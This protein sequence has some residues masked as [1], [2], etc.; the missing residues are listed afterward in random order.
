M[1][2]VLYAVISILTLAS[3]A[4]TYS[5]SGSSNVSML[6]GQKLYLKVYKDTVLKNIDSCDVV[7]GHFQFQGSIDSVRIA[8]IFVDDNAGLPVVLESGEIFVKIDNTQ[9][10]VTGTPLNDK[11]S[12]FREKFTQLMNQSMDLVHR[13]DQAIMN[14]KDMTVVN[15]QLA[16]E[17]ANINKKMDDLVTTFVTDNF[18]N[19]LGPYVFINTCLSRYEVP[20]LD[21][22]IEDIMSKA[23]D[24]FKNNIHVKEYYEAAQQNQ[25]IMNGMQDMPQQTPA[26]SV[27]PPMDGPTPNQMATSP[28]DSQIPAQ[29]PSASTE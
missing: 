4:D 8:N 26:G 21:A 27:A 16:A 24:K 3:C 5:I 13:H 23:T 19:I 6:D 1:N 11:L 18:D 25:N 12:E 7:H 20:M 28:D 15:A 29:K 14:G 2:K 9:E 22:W 17:D 10:S